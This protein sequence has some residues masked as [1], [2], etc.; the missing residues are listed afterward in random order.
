MASSL[1]SE[2]KRWLFTK[3]HILECTP[4]RIAGVPYEKELSYR[5]QAANFIQDM[6]QRLKVTQLC[7]NT[8]I[9]FMHRFYM[10]HSF[11]NFPRNGLCSASLFLAAKVEEQPRKMEYVIQV[12][13]YC[14]LRSEVKIDLKQESYNKVFGLMVYYESTLLQT[15]GFVVAV[16]HPHTYVV[17]LCHLVRANKELAQTSYFMASNSL[18]LTTM[19]LQHPPSVVACLCI[20][21]ASKWSNWEIPVSHE[22]N[23]WHH[24]VDPNV[25]PE[26]MESLTT[27]FLHIIDKCPSRL[28][29]MSK[30]K[31]EDN[32]MFGSLE[33]Y[34]KKSG[35]NSSTSARPDA[36][37]DDQRRVTDKRPREAAAGK[38]LQGTRPST[39]S[40]AVTLPSHHHNQPR[41]DAPAQK[42]D[43]A[44]VPK[45]ASAIPSGRL[46]GQMAR[47]RDELSQLM[48][49]RPHHNM[50]R[51]REGVNGPNDPMVPQAKKSRE[52]VPP[53][54]DFSKRG[55][56]GEFDALRMG[57][58]KKQPEPLMKMPAQPAPQQKHSMP[59]P[60]SSRN[61]EPSH[62]A[63]NPDKATTTTV[64][65]EA[66]RS[67]VDFTLS[68][69]FS[70]EG[71]N[72][73]ESSVPN[74]V[75]F[76]MEPPADGSPEV[77]DL[78]AIIADHYSSPDTRNK[79]LDLSSVEIPEERP[80]SHIFDLALSGCLPK[81]VVP[82][83][84]LTP[85]KDTSALPV[86]KLQTEM[87]TLL[88]ESSAIPSPI[89]PVKVEHK[90]SIFDPIDEPPCAT[91]PAEVLGSTE[92]HHKKR[93]K[94]KHGKKDKE[95]SKDERKHKH[96]KKDKSKERHRS[97]ESSEPSTSAMPAPPTTP[98][99][100]SIPKDKLESPLGSL[101]IKIPKARVKVEEPIAAP[102]Q[103]PT[104]L[105]I[106]IKIGKE[107]MTERSV[108]GSDVRKCQ[109]GN[110]RGRSHKS[111]GHQDVRKAVDQ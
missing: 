38:D 107:L 70:P 103:P 62:H 17:K 13:V 20:H 85:G 53:P 36:K 92:R 102:A 83:V 3:E 39:P 32:L 16:D 54:P 8:A 19:C 50:K 21:L 75:T 110:S 66:K 82:S 37:F 52:A 29:R 49:S 55:G 1:E 7:I 61:P 96:K 30:D 81:I 87:T 59:K 100:M 63:H 5:Q 11:V 41:R 42:R 6:G 67:S 89:A 72:Q 93:K 33:D 45:P 97:E 79:E 65:A 86:E 25:T 69:I 68:H 22:G 23:P 12:A 95:R 56:V 10:H 105:P 104:V 24:Y 77:P 88:G 73:E 71:G 99:K 101:K 34:E 4:S 90:P 51:P 76:S 84:P 94:E 80:E 27:E 40:G 2:D 98:L 78:I 58:V 43:F 26:L 35:D 60:T 31:T 18:H 14:L 64:A 74:D 48:Q 44:G 47:N 15:L 109:D 28:K 91:L 106:K 9:T 57:S 46:D 111:N 108:S